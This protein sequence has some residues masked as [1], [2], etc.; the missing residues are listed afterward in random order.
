MTCNLRVKMLGG[1]EFLVPLTHSMTVSEL[2]QLIVHKSGVPA[3]QQRLAH[4]SGKILQENVTLISQGLR[5]G[6]TVML[7]VQNC[8]NPLSILV[9]N[10]RG[11]SSIY[12]VRLTQT[13]A[14][15]KKQVSQEEHVQ[16]DQF[17]L[18]FEGRPMEDQQPLG[19]YDLKPQCT[20]F[21]N[22]RLRGGGYAMPEASIWSQ[23]W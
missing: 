11:R 21:M 13:V 18:S 14:E 1:D 9:R 16:E 10:D 19:E 2:K 23:Y 20:V 7:M 3:F 15:L 5:A 17:W 22:L 4:E 8:N 12:E 6:S